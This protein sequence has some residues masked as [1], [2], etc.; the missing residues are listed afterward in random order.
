MLKLFGILKREDVLKSIQI[1]KIFCFFVF[2][3]VA[4]LVYLFH[5]ELL[6]FVMEKISDRRAKESA[7]EISVLTPT[8]NRVHFLPNSVNSILNQEYKNFELVILD[9]GSTDHT[10]YLLL[11]YL[12]KDNRIRVYFNRQNRGRPYSRNKLLNLSKGNYIAVMD[13]DDFSF[14][15]R[16]REQHDYM[17]NHPEVDVVSAYSKLNGVIEEPVSTE[18]MMVDLVFNSAITHSTVMLKKA[19]L[20]EHHINYDEKYATVDDY[21]LYAKLLLAGAKFYMIPKYL[22]NLRVHQTNGRDYYRKQHEES[23]AISYEI[24]SKLFG[25]EDELVTLNFCEKMK[26]L[27][28]AN[29]KWKLFDNQMLEEIKNNECS[30]V[31][32]Y[33]I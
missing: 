3:V 13:S 23:V 24:Q 32:V 10:L 2:I 4:F 29:K 27:C 11:K 33:Q 26:L 5:A 19:F 18:R 15:N 8:Y 17:V 6:M 20:D 22:I 30:L 14:S 31:E 28:E 12:I 9:D 1:K 7:P 16:L 25:H 21:S